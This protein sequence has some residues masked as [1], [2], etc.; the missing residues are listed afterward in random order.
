MG[1]INQNG[2][3]FIVGSNKVKPL[4]NKVY[5]LSFSMENGFFLIEKEDFKIPS[6][7]YG[8]HSVINRWKKSYEINSEKNL[9]IILSGMK[10]TGKTITS[11]LFCK[12]MNLPVIIINSSFEG[13]AFVD[14]ITNPE[15]GRAIIFIDEFEK[16]Y[17][18]DR[19]RDRD[20]SED[21]LSVMDGNFPTKL[22]FLLTVNEYKINPYLINRLNRIKYR[23][24]YDSLESEVIEEVIEDMLV[25]KE[26]KNSIYDFFDIVGMVTFDLLVNVI[27]EMNLFKEDALS[28][29]K[30]LNL[31]TVNTLYSISEIIDGCEYKTENREFINFSLVSENDVHNVEI[32]RNE[33]SPYF[34]NKSILTPVKDDDDYEDEDDD[35]E[36]KASPLVNVSNEKHK[37]IY[38]SYYNFDIF[39]SKVL[40]EGKSYLV[41]DKNGLVFRFKPVNK[42]SLVF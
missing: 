20:K 18:I 12:K 11:Q 29:G 42:N 10:G 23:K 39:D 38:G 22:I 17:N 26:H 8:D 35:D 4:E 1:W 28:V 24:H 37:N 19:D 36:I 14:F 30:Y 5:L 16:V 34:H 13:T 2:K 3:H 41:T 21:L 27:K 25:N 40:K 7:I 9:G 15:F 31:E 33:N 32:Y 6:K